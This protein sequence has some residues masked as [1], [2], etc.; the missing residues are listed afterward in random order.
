ML[1]LLK[2]LTDKMDR[3]KGRDKS[4]SFFFYHHINDPRWTQCRYDALSEEGF[5]KNVVAFRSVNLIAKGVA[6]IPISVVNCD[7]GT[8]NSI[9]TNLL[10]NPTPRQG[11]GTFFENIVNYLL[12]AGNAFVHYCS[13]SDDDMD[14]RRKCGAFHEELATLNCLRPDRMQIIPD[15]TKTGVKSYVY[16]VDVTK[17]SLAKEDVLHLKFFNPLNDWY[18]FGP[19]QAAMSAIDQHNAMSKHNLAILQNGGR[20]S[21]CLMVKGGM[22]N[23]T[24][25]Q[26]EQLREDIRNSYIGSKNAGKVLVL[27]GN[28]EWKEMGLSP[29]DLDFETG[30]NI[31]SRE[32][33]MA[34]GVP[35][36]LVGIPGDSTFTSYRE[37]RLHLWEDTIL[38]LAESIRLEFSAWLSQK[39]SRQVELAFN[40]DDVHALTLRREIIWNRISQ[41]DFLDDAEKRSLLGFSP[42]TDKIQN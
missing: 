32:I 42:T 13:L 7:D 33:A 17:F 1:N 6:S 26:R 18:G 22:E 19:M 14:N 20:P 37:A 9:A 36:M 10:K 35:P 31:T 40:L 29:K 30:K 24:Q 11:R 27:E 4:D 21:G 8:E 5:Q 23:L 16:A 41:A 2:N 38:P 12:I 3:K 15:A 25:E 34:F 28:F 39:I